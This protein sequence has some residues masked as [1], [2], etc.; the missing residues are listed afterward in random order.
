MKLFSNDAKSISIVFICDACDEET[1]VEA[2]EVP[3][4]GEI[5]VEATC[6]VCFKEFEVKIIRK[7]GKS[8]VE[9]EDVEDDDITITVEN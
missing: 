3:E 6:P 2:T 7:D 8:W 9:I 4:E 1:P 5:M